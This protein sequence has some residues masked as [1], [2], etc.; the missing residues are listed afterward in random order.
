VQIEVPPPRTL[1]QRMSILKVHTKNM[2]EAGRILVADAPI[3]S[4]A[5]RYVE[6]RLVANNRLPCDCSPLTKHVDIGR[7]MAR[8]IYRLTKS[9]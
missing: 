5:G 9:F 4:A 3:D 1:E 2:Y 8:K 6:V 7:H